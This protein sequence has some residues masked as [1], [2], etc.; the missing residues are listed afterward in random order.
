MKPFFEAFPTLQLK[1]SIAEQM[2]DIQVTR[3]GTNHD[4]ILLRVYIESTRPL[5]R[6]MLHNVE[7]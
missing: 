2:E 5:E 1:N 3:V 7:Y 4:N 6:Q